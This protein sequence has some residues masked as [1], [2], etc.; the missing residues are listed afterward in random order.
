MKIALA[1]IGSRGDIQP[2]IALAGALN[3]KGFRTFIATHPYAKQLVESY[4]IRHES[5][6]QDI[7]IK[8]EVKKILQKSNSPTRGLYPTIRFIIENLRR[9]HKDFIKLFSDVDLVIAGHN[10]TGLAE[11]EML[12]KLFVRIALEESDVPRRKP[13]PTSAESAKELYAPFPASAFLKSYKKFRMEI[14][15]PPMGN[16]CAYPGLTL[17]PVSQAIQKENDLWTDKAVVTGYFFYDPPGDFIRDDRLLSFMAKGEN[18]VF[19]SMGSMYQD[20]KQSHRFINTVVRAIH[21]AHE[22]AIIQVSGVKPV[23]SHENIMF[24]ENIPYSWL[25]KHVTLVIHHCGFGTTAEVLKY[26]LPSVPFPHIFTQWKLATRIYRLGLA[27]QPLNIQK[28]T[29]KQLADA[30]SATKRNVQMKKCVLEI[31]RIIKKE[32]GL[33]KAVDLICKYY[34]NRETYK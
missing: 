6:G 31:S 28:L 11:A 17:F 27:H 21:M 18:P 19:V 10:M 3:K 34:D 4:G 13:K 12:Q 1:T 8:T 25:F 32:N 2:Y 23:T 5:A 29:D 30:I 33:K 9:C 16:N 7:D 20:K 14:G 24:V 26:G 22:R 15:A